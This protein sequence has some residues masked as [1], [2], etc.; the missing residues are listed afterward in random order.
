LVHVRKSKI[1]H[2]TGLGLQHPR[3][4]SDAICHVHEQQA[5]AA[6]EM[7]EPSKRAAEAIVKQ[8]DTLVEELTHGHP[9]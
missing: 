3:C 2:L 6:G 5:L 1:E 7:Q 4:A 9:F 8:Q